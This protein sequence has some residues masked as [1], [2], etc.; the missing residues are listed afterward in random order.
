MSIATAVDPYAWERQ[1]ACAKSSDPDLW[2]ADNQRGR[3]TAV[4]ICQRHCPVLAQCEARRIADPQPYSVQAGVRYTDDPIR[5][6]PAWHQPKPSG[7]NCGIC[8]ARR[9]VRWPV[10][11]AWPDCGDN[12]AYRRHRELG[13][14][15]CESCAEWLRMRRNAQRA[16]QRKLRRARV[17]STAAAAA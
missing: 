14:K 2:F 3:A 9:P 5:P 4:H 17:A 12:V 16:A 15:P 8:K 10:A 6:E 7:R 13:Q 1:A 11:K